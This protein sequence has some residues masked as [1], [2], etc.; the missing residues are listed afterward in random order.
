MS[1][2][3]EFTIP[4]FVPMGNWNCLPFVEL[5]GG[6]PESDVTDKFLTRKLFTGPSG[7]MLGEQSTEAPGWERSRRRACAQLLCHLLSPCIF[8]RL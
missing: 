5:L 4:D 8:C 3:P 6:S 1:L 7:K 2:S